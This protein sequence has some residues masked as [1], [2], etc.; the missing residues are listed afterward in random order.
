MKKLACA[1][2]LASAVAVS[3]AVSPVSAGSSHAAPSVICDD[4]GSVFN[5][6]GRLAP[7][8]TARSDGGRGEKNTTDVVADSNIPAGEEPATSASFTA[9]IPVW[10]HV[11]AASR[12]PAD[13]WVSNTQIRDQMQVLNHT[14]AGGRGG[15]DTGFRFRLAGTTRTINADWFAQETFADEVE[16][17]SAL[18]RGDAT[19]LNIYSTS[20]GGFLGWAY[21]PK[22]V[23]YQ[24]FQVLDGVVI[25]FGSMPGGHIAR[26][27]LGFTATHEAGHW[28]GLA[29]TFE[30]GCQ[31][32]GD[33]VD[34]TP[35]EA[36]PTSRCPIG[37]DTCPEPGLDPIHN[38]MD[39]SD[40]ACYTE[41]TAG[42]ALRTHEQYVHWRVEHGY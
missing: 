20:G 5:S 25:H 12:K 18:K 16:M 8:S 10:F 26:F 6:L 3:F 15:A 38:Y 34:D 40:D 23:V 14:F 37:K 36:V 17:K 9:T 35:A 2:A 19:T 4:S 11:V 22:I 39:Y 27:N 30:D 24:H 1:L 32:H 13:G 41:F 42:Q 28:L 29:H 7:S 21:Y 31:G 33:H